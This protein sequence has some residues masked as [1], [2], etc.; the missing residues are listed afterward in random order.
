MRNAVQV[1]SVVGLLLVAPSAVA[2]ETEGSG[3]GAE[4]ND[5]RTEAQRNFDAAEEA[6]DAAAL[7]ALKAR[8][9]QG[10]SKPRASQDSSEP[11][12]EVRLLPVTPAIQEAALAPLRSAGVVAQDAQV[13]SSSMFLMRDCYHLVLTVADLGRPPRYHLIVVR[14]PAPLPECTVTSREIDS[15][16]VDSFQVAVKGGQGFALAFQ[17]KQTPSGSGLVHVRLFQI[18]PKDLS[19][20]RAEFLGTFRGSTWVNE[21]HFEGHRLVVETNRYTATYP[22]FLTSTLP[23]EG[24]IF[25]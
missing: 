4:L 15:S 17:S 20:V 7:Q 8:V 10:A 11:V 12:E 9:E 25:P 23:P 24:V 2:T 18:A 21:M 19:V 22:R 5:S 14:L 1:L 13:Q 16:Y 6:R 3:E